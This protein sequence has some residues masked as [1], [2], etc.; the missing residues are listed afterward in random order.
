MNF[1]KNNYIFTV[2]Q[3]LPATRAILNSN[4]FYKSSLARV[5]TTKYFIGQINDTDFKIIGSSAKSPACVL[6]GKL[7]ALD[8]YTTLVEIDTTLHK[9]FRIL[10]VIW[11]GFVA[12]AMIIPGFV[13]FN[14]RQ[15]LSGIAGAVVGAIVFRLMLHLFY[16]RARN[17]SIR[18]IESILQ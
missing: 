1:S 9:A 11:V 7:I 18:N 3:S 13:H 4:T 15:L 12:L 5:V 17:R 10:F 2:N 16:I 6:S 14:L 8:D